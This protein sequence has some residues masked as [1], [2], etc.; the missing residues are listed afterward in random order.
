M[1]VV[2]EFVYVSDDAHCRVALF[3]AVTGEFVT[4][5]GGHSDGN[6]KKYKEPF[7]IC[8]DKSKHIH[9]SHQQETSLM[10]IIFTSPCLYSII[11]S[12]CMLRPVVENSGFELGPI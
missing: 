2:G 7:R 12:P 3:K 8:Y 11:L 9:T 4:S 5:F 10:I 1:T 6:G